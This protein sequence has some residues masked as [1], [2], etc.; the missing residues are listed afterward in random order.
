M[1]DLEIIIVLVLLSLNVIPH[2]SQHSLTFP[3]SRFRDS[4]TV[5]LTSEDGRTA[6]NVEPLE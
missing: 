3:S 2:R 1:C 5:T 6:I 4:A